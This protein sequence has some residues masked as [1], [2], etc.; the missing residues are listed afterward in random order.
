MEVPRD[1]HGTWF[2]EAILRPETLSE[3]L[4]MKIGEPNLIP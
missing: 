4:L 1:Y 3:H 2:H